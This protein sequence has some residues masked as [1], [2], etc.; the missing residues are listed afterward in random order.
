MTPESLLSSIVIFS[1]GFVLIRAAVSQSREFWE[2]CVKCD[3]TSLNWM[4][5]HRPIH[6]HTHT[7]THIGQCITQSILC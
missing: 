1:K 5:A 7:N 3:N 4:P 6:I 2:H